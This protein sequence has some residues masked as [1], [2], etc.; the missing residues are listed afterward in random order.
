MPSG[1]WYSPAEPSTT[2]SLVDM[3]HIVAGIPDG[4][5]VAGQHVYVAATDGGLRVFTVAEPSLPVQVGSYAVLPY[6]SEVA[7]AGGYAYIPAENSGLRVVD[8]SDPMAPVEV[9]VYDTAG[10]A[11]SIVV[12]DDFAYVA[13][14]GTGVWIVNVSDPTQPQY[15]GLYDHV[16][17]PNDI[18][19]ADHHLY[20]AGG[21][22]HVV[23]VTDPSQPVEMGSVGTPG[24]ALNVQ[25]LGNFA[26]VADLAGGLR[27]INIEDPANPVEVG[28]HMTPDW[29]S[30]VA[31][32]GQHAYVAAEGS[33]LR[34]IDISDPED[35]FEVS[36]FDPPEWAIKVAAM[37]GYVYL[38]AG[39]LNILDV[40]DPAHPTSVGSYNWG[41]GVAA[42]EYLYVASGRRGLLV[43]DFLE[44]GDGWQIETVAAG[45]WFWDNSLALDSSGRAH[46]AYYEAMEGDLRYAVRDGTEWLEE[47]VE[48]VGD[49]GKYC[50]LAL[51]SGGHPH[52]SYCLY[53]GNQ[54]TCTE[55][56]YAFHDGTDW[57]V[58]VVDDAGVGS[59]SSLALDAAGQPH[60]SYYDSTEEVLKYA[61]YDGSAWHLETVDND[62]NAGVGASLALDSRGLPH[63]AYESHEA[64]GLKYARYDGTEWLFDIID[65]GG[66]HSA[67]LKIGTDDHPHVGYQKASYPD[68]GYLIYKY[69]DGTAWQTK[70]V[71]DLGDDASYNT[72]LALDAFGQPHISYP[73]RSGHYDLRCA[74]RH[75]GVWHVET[76]DAAAEVACCTSLAMQRYGLEQISYYDFARQELRYAYRESTGEVLQRVYL[77]VVLR[78]Y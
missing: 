42:E 63:I 17:S 14:F 5:S 19:V 33:G 51:D 27:I 12:S 54:Y 31:V 77:P 41:G 1:S 23:D 8:I 75:G 40:S 20:V 25:V 11:E 57:H 70:L 58:E 4:I 71:D 48:E 74:H 76:V 78:R 34:V 60:I 13:D 49:V 39:G 53:D 47:T 64:N 46:I 30:D 62:E 24:S 36:Y 43:L 28:F 66:G 72:S 52:I 21:G 65:S 50:S 68:Y 59:Y 3:A 56:R 18:E 26:Y 2:I 45:G 38:D 44:P 9:A 29:A 37:D 32:L 15:A 16:S 67:S 69:H 55:L 6:A 10:W 22:L 7:V 35:P 61:R 73:Y